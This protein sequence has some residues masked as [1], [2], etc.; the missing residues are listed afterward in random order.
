MGR[1]G[2]DKVEGE[3]EDRPVAE[4]AINVGVWRCANARTFRVLPVPALLPIDK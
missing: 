3:P 2:V 4:L 1:Q